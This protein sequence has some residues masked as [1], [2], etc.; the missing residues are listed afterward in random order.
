MFGFGRYA[1]SKEM[2]DWLLDGLIWCAGTGL[3]R[4]DTPLVTPTKDWFRAPS[5]ATSE[6]TARA[7]LDDILRIVGMTGAAIEM[8]PIEVLPDEL[9]H[10][11]G[12][13]G[14]IAGTWQGDGDGPSLI[15]YDPTLLRRPTVFLS[16]M[17]HE[18]MHE[19]LHHGPGDWP[20][21][22]EAEELMTDL[23]VI[24]SGFG[25]LAL[26]G[27]EDAGWQGYMRQDSRAH[28]VALVLGAMGADPAGAP[29]HLPGRA[30]KALKAAIAHLA[31]NDD[32][33]EL[34]QSLDASGPQPL[35]MG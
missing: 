34:R 20:G 18:V 25:V 12:Q 14:E 2:Q 27:A 26:S 29:A 17:A 31:T 8:L 10:Q 3:L 6:V 7:L 16:T 30:A 32:V 21:G 13:M 15:R 23:A 9:R 28:A 11:Y 22:P 19:R 5:G 1:V 33:A 24:A 35:V 4:P